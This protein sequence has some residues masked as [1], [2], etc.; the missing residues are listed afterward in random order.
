MK[1]KAAVVVFLGS[2]CDRDAHD[3]LVHSGYETSY[4]WH[5]ESSIDPSISLV[6]LPG[7]FSYGDYLR[8][9]AISARSNIIGAIA[10]FAKKGGKVIGICNGFQILTESGLLPGAL[11]RNSKTDFI[12]KDLFI[13]TANKTSCFTAKM[14]EDSRCVFKVPVAHHDG[15]YF[16]DADGLKKLQDN[17]QIA[18]KYCDAD[19]SEVNLNGSVAGIAGILSADKNILGMMPHPER[20]YQKELGSEDGNLILNFENAI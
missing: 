6:V 19:A 15:N 9:G 1:K 13:T 18:F 7:G 5:K 8:C 12:C 14:A 3:A 16:I 2:N 4:I 11:L 10:E 20:A 17:D